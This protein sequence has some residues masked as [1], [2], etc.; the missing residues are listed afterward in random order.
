MRRFPQLKAK[1]QWLDNLEKIDCDLHEEL[2][3][4]IDYVDEGEYLL[5]EGKERI[6]RETGD[7]NG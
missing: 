4:L 7:K 2:Q 3:L 6:I 1:L 5:K